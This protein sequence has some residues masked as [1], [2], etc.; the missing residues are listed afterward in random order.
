[1]S[2]L[3]I[4]S[5]SRKSPKTDRSA[6]S[7]QTPK[8]WHWK[9]CH[10][11]I[12]HAYNISASI[13]E[14]NGAYKVWAEQP[15]PAWVAVNSLR[16]IN[17]NSYKKKESQA[18]LGPDPEDTG[19]EVF[20]SPL[21]NYKRPFRVD[22]ATSVLWG[23]VF[24]AEQSYVWCSWT[25]CPA[26]HRVSHSVCASH[27]GTWR[28]FSLLFLHMLSHQMAGPREVPNDGENISVAKDPQLHWFLLKP[29]KQTTVDQQSRQD[30]SKLSAHLPFL[31]ACRLLWQIFFLRFYC[32]RSL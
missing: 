19:I 9:C 27:Q 13:W 3:A 30:V 31:H 17:K 29:E 2:K 7:C 28:E 4:N 15:Q 25:L 11:S 32:A 21:P 5:F 18:P 14:A 6:H 23:N 24:Y 16:Q 8:Q 1:M 22:V 26:C 12:T 10:A 20:F